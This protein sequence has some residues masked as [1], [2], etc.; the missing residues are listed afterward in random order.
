[1]Q[2]KITL[3]YI[4]IF[5]SLFICTGCSQ[6]TNQIEA[7]CCA[8]V[9]IQTL[10][11]VNYQHGGYYYDHLAD[12]NKIL[13][14]TIYDTI[15][16]IQ[17]KKVLDKNNKKENINIVF[18]SILYDHPEFYYVNG[19][20]LKQTSQ[21]TIFAPYYTKNDSEIV[22]ENKKI[23]EYY[24]KTLSNLVLGQGDYETIKSLYEYLVK[25]TTYNI[26]N[27]DNNN[28]CSVVDS[29]STVCG[30]FSKIAAYILNK[31]GIPTTIIT[32]T[33]KDTNT[34]HMWNAV[35][36]DGNWYYMDVTWGITN[37]DDIL[38]GVNY[39]YMLINQQLLSRSHVINNLIDVPD[40]SKMD[41]SYY[42]KSGLYLNGNVSS[43]QLNS[44]LQQINDNGEVKFMCAEYNTY[45]SLKTVLIENRGIYDYINDG[46]DI[47]Y[48]YNDNLYILSFWKK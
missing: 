16:S 36:V 37:C 8:S 9:E 17:T 27:K 6:S 14:E 11:S 38:S 39:D 25:T 7:S 31:V 28:I 45:I 29:S 43:G 42:F 47:N 18:Q 10:P 4:I 15:R 19:Y 34:P 30:G 5:L 20:S 44:I 33:I 13:Y 35:Y 3:I 23:E 22:I 41:N 32:G 21:N 46:D 2:R 24:N 1:M 26:D 12:N 48:S 40:C